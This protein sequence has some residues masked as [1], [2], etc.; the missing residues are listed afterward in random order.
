MNRSFIKIIFPLAIILSALPHICL[1]AD[2][3]AASATAPMPT[4]GS[5]SPLAETG[6]LF[7][8]IFKVLGSLAVVIGLMMIVVWWIKKLGIGKGVMRKG[9]LIN[10]LDTRMIAPKKYVAVLEV[11]GEFVVV[12][13]TDQNINFLTRLETETEL[14]RENL[15]PGSTPPVA[16]PFAASLTAAV[17]KFR[18]KDGK[19]NR[20][21]TP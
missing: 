2:P 18:K 16:M 6:G 20:W 21:N 8:A 17:N 1:G 13:V 15:P 19:D 12:G 9:S 5:G 11:G 4:L 14:L 7:M 3:G 10:I